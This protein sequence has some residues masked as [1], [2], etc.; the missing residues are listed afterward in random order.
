MVGEAVPAAGGTDRQRAQQRGI[1]A[2][3]QAGDG[4]LVGRTLDLFLTHSKDAMLRLARAMKARD[5]KEIAS[6]AHALKSMSYNVGARRLGEAC[7]AVE[8][9]SA[10]LSVLPDLLRAVRREYAAAIDEAPTVKRRYTRAAA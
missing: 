8:R 10:E 4:D 2:G 3:L 5:P 6:A 1:A 9:R 7:A